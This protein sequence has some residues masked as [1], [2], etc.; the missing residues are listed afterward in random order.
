M[1]IKLAIFLIVL[2]ILSIANAN[3]EGFNL[4]SN[5]F[6]SDGVLPVL[7]TCDGKG[8]SPQLSWSDAPEKTEAYVLIANEKESTPVNYIW[9]LYIPK[10][11]KSI[12]ENRPLP[13]QIKVVKTYTPPCAPKGG[14]SH[15]NFTIYALS[16]TVKID[17]QTT[18]ESIIGSIENLI[19]A[20]A[21]INLPYP[22]WY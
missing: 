12:Q 3:A 21:E 14:M 18:I 15:Y 20:K 16:K 1:D 17:N 10:H 22:R 13:K 19:L 5:D 11:I 6:T 4:K 7:Y 8:I 2:L 9:A